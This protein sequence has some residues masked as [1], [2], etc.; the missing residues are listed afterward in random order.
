MKTANIPMSEYLELLDIKNNKITELK[1]E[2]Q[3]HYEEK[4]VEAKLNYNRALSQ[5]KEGLEMDKKELTNQIKQ[6][7]NKWYYKLFNW[8][9]T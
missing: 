6:L 5:I 2:L 7:K 4:V 1:E 9:T 3:M 8:T